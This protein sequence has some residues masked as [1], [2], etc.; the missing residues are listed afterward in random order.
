MA[1]FSRSFCRMSSG[2]WL[3]GVPALVPGLGPALLPTNRRRGFAADRA[4]GGSI[5][6]TV[7]ADIVV[8]SKQGLASGKAQPAV[9]ASTVHNIKLQF[10]NST[11]S[12]FT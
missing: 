8:K 9:T 7:G 3:A 10:D 1:E 6:A 2:I 5:V 11:S 12:S 4:L